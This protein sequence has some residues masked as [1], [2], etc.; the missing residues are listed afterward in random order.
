MMAIAAPEVSRVVHGAG[1][2]EVAVEGDRAVDRQRDRG[3]RE[4]HRS[5]QRQVDRHARELL[6]P[7]A[8]GDRQERDHVG[9]RQRPEGAHERVADEPDAV[10]HVVLDAGVLHARLL[11][12][13]AGGDV[14]ERLE[15]ARPRQVAQHDAPPDEAAEQEDGGQDR[16]HAGAR[17]MAR[18]PGELLLSS[19]VGDHGH[20][21]EDP[22]LPSGGPPSRVRMSR[23]PIRRGGSGSI[24]LRPA[25]RDTCS[26][27]K[28][29][30]SRTGAARPMSASIR[31]RVAS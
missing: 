28:R 27:V 13:R 10:V 29:T 22:R 30:R 15:E 8:G 11:A 19:F 25:T 24:S 4:Q 26:P 7:R 1:G 12:D 18:L 20:G 21:D 23:S 16:G 5:D 2:V 3:D 6:A 17:A 9:Q 31:R 14:A